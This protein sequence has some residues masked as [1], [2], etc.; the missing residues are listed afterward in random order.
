MCLNPLEIGNLFSMKMHN[1]DLHK[2]EK[3]FITCMYQLG[4]WNWC[5]DWLIDYLNTVQN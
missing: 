3:T 4:E 2:H 5:T 1:P